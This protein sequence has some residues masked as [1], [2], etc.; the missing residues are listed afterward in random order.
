MYAP[1]FGVL[2][3]SHNCPRCPEDRV[4]INGGQKKEHILLDL[5]LGKDLASLSPLSYS[6]LLTSH[7]LS[8]RHLL[9]LC[10][11]HIVF[12]PFKLIIIL[13]SNSGSPLLFSNQSVTLA[14]S[15]PT[16]ANRFNRP[17]THRQAFPLRQYP[18][19]WYTKHG[20][21]PGRCGSSVPVLLHTALGAFFPVILD[22]RSDASLATSLSDSLYV[23]S[24]KRPASVQSSAQN[25]SSCSRSMTGRNSL[26][27]GLQ[28]S[29]SSHELACA[30]P[31]KTSSKNRRHVSSRSLRRQRT[32][33]CVNRN[34]V[35]R[36]AWN[37]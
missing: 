26:A 36:W 31:K 10:K 12:G 3:A 17:Q 14:P 28:R 6:H 1:R 4:G 2:F 22:A 7:A 35:A 37:L 34:G 5:P 15:Q 25:A 13:L 16:Q 9:R 19:S 32:L 20:S 21:F 24:R 30:V 18:W 29:R 8:I 27:A 23:L 33:G 11:Q